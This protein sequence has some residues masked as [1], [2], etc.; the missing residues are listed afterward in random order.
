MDI[1]SNEGTKLT[2]LSSTRRTIFVFFGKLNLASCRTLGR[3]GTADMGA[4]GGFGNDICDGGVG[5]APVAGG[6]GPES[7]A[8]IENKPFCGCGVEVAIG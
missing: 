6:G 4:G 3:F 1:T 7:A 2:P 5:A 8:T